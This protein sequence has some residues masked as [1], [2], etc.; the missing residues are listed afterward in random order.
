MA[1]RWSVAALLIGFVPTIF[2][3][4]LLLY[5][6]SNRIV[7]PLTVIG[8]IASPFAAVFNFVA[9]QKSDR[10]AARRAAQDVERGEQLV[11]AW[12]DDKMQCAQELERMQET[13]NYAVQLARQRTSHG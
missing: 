6:D 10:Q 2:A 5:K 9:K 3:A 1:N 4:P 13:L 11:R 7:I 12:E 8:A